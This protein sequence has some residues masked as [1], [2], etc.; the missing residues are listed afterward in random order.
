M[1]TLSIVLKS[2]TGENT[3]PLSMIVNRNECVAMIVAGC[4]R[5]DYSMDESATVSRS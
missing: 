5:Q 4:K 2:D 1:T 3:H